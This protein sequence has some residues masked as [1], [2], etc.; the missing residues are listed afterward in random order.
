MTIT[1]A[2]V[3]SELAAKIERRKGHIQQTK[4]LIE[5]KTYHISITPGGSNS[6]AMCSAWIEADSKSIAEA[7][8]KLAEE[9][10]AQWEAKLAEM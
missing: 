3:A 10:L 4:D 9:E 5:A 8:L 1:D 7:L 6:A 2:K